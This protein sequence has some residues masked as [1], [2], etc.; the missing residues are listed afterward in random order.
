MA[1]TQ[2]KNDS[3]A[4]R[5]AEQNTAPRT[6]ALPTG[7]SRTPSQAGSGNPGGAS[8]DS[9]PTITPSPAALRREQL[10]MV[11]RMALAG[12]GQAPLPAEDYA[13]FYEGL[14]S[15]LPPSGA[16]AAL[17]AATCIGEFLRAQRDIISRLTPA[18]GG[19]Q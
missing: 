13:L 5:R 2:H 14:G 4:R 12:L 6:D 15:I 7:S 18:K 9:F 17:Y 1:T 8:A 3:N 16:E 11:A 10:D 19:C